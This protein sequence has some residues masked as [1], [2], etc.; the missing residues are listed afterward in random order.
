MAYTPK[1]WL[2]FATKTTPINSNAL[3][4]LEQR[5]VSF[6]AAEAV[7]PGAYGY[8]DFRVKQN[9]AGANMQV[10]VGLAATEMNAW[11]RDAAQG[12]YRYQYNGAQL[13]VT[14]PVADGTNPRIDRIVMTAPTSIDSIV[15]QVLCL[16][17]TP[18]G[19]ATLDNLS[20]AQVV[21]TGYILLADVLVGAGVVSIVTANIRER[22]G[23]GGQFNLGVSPAGSTQS[24][25]SSARDEVLIQPSESLVVG[26][27]TW[28]PT[29]HDNMQGAYLGFLTRRIVNATRIRWKYAQ[30]AT[31]AA[32]NYN[33]AIV[34]SSGRLVIAGGAV[35]LA[36]GANSIAEQ[37]VTIAATTFEPGPLFVWFGVAAL[38]AASALSFTGVQGNVSVT[39]PGA[40]FRNRKVHSATGGTT[41]PASNTL[42]AYTDVAAQTAAANNLPLPLV[43]LSV[44]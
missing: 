27:Q 3:K 28:T 16:A 39:A 5:S 11:V 24:S 30:G 25:G 18:T 31:P 20:G 7:S 2:N 36:G 29:T 34:D 10:G 42:A 26:A 21:P 13:L 22:R 8:E 19:G 6:A 40:P 4:A 17:G 35:A 44:G 43:S 41:F 32:T 23:V 12:I 14:C 15:P 1:A 9:P 37:A 33:V 38:T